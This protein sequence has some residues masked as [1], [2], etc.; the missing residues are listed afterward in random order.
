M[1]SRDWKAVDSMG[2]HFRGA[3]SG[4]KMKNK[5]LIFMITGLADLSVGSVTSKDL[6]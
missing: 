4:N 1:V 6:I 5:Y 2:M 3:N